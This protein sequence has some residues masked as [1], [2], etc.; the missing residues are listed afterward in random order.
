LLE[1][2]LVSLIWHCPTL[3]SLFSFVGD[4]F[5]SLGHYESVRTAPSVP[6]Q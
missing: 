2:L 1:I 4:I 5:L 6:T 3:A